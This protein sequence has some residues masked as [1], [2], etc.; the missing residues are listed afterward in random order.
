MNARFLRQQLILLMLW[1]AVV[2]TY[3]AINPAPTVTTSTCEGIT[4]SEL[5]FKDGDRKVSY[6]LPM[7]WTYR[8]RDGGIQ[9]T[10]PEKPF[11]DAMIRIV[12]LPKAHSLDEKAVEAFKDRF[13]NSLPSGSQLVKVLLEEQNPVLIENSPSYEITATYH[14]MG[15]TFMR[16]GLV[17]NL[18][19]TQL[20]FN[21]TARKADF[22][23]LHRAF[24]A[25]LISWQWVEKPSATVAARP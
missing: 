14:I 11:A 24:R 6:Q 25:S 22:D 16:S 13:L 5:V 10:P 2:G 1:F 7:Q 20:S 18:S 3:G 4:F 21:F 9:L 19:D 15:E 17:T 23:A 12:P 8:L